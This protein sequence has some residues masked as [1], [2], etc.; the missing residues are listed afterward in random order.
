MPGLSLTLAHW[1][2]SGSKHLHVTRSSI[3]SV[4]QVHVSKPANCSGTS[5]SSPL[6][7]ESSKNWQTEQSPETTRSQQS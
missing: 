2:E 7:R 6:V 5:T 4:T 3:P 1:H